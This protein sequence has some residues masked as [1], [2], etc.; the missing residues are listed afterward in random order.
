MLLAEKLLASFQRYDSRSLSVD[1]PVSLK[2]ET[3]LDMDADRCAYQCMNNKDIDCSSFDFC[4][5]ETEEGVSQSTCHLHDVHLLSS[6]AVQWKASE[7]HCDHYAS[8][9]AESTF[10][11]TNLT[12]C[13]LAELHTFDYREYSGESL[14]ENDLGDY[15]QVSV[16]N[17]NFPQPVALTTLQPCRWKSAPRSVPTLST[18][19]LST[20]AFTMRTNSTSKRPP[21]A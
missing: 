18:A 21:V 9:F 12:P 4:E 1:A 13:A 20:T 17:P 11:P 2:S 7:T 5:G 10:D 8:K 3:S 6:S 14:K 16:S 15:E 19:A